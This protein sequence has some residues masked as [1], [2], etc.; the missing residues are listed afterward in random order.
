MGM[1]KL[2]A[3]LM[4][5]AQSEIVLRVLVEGFN[6]Q[7][8]AQ[9]DHACACFDVSEAPALV[10]RLAADD[11]EMIPAFDIRIFYFTH[12]FSSFLYS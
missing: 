1:P 2:S 10:Y 4:R 12:Y 6:A 9:R 3:N 11:A 5:R 7:R 8:T